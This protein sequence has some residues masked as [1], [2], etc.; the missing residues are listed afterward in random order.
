LPPARST[1]WRR[2]LGGIALASAALVGASGCQ[3]VQ[4][5]MTIRSNPPG[6]LVLVDGREIGYTPAS[7]DFTYYATREVTVVKDGYETL[8]T[9]QRFEKPWYQYPGV[10]F[11]SDNFLPVTVTNRHDITYN[12]RPSAVQPAGDLRDRADAYR[13]RALIGR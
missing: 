13:S 11:V 8:T 9:L 2:W 6:A 1:T 7:V 3:S 4:R 5:R 12:L 10:E